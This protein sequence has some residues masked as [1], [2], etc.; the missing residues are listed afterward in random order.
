MDVKEAIGRMF[1]EIER[2]GL[3]RKRSQLPPA[4]RHL[5][6]PALLGRAVPD[7]LQGRHRLPA[8]RGQAAARAA[9]RSPTSAPRS[10]ASRRWPASRSGRRRKAIRYELIDHARIRR[11]VGLLPALHGP[12]QRSGARRPGSRRILAQRG[13][14]RRRHRARHGTPHV[15]ALLEHVPLRPRR[16]SARRSRSA[17]SSIRA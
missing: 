9:S 1:D 4:R 12:A 3:G 10:R 15:L 7:L 11:I 6:A 14:L 2:R 13:P 8:R 17:N 5:L 16:W